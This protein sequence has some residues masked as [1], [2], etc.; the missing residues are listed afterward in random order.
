MATKKARVLVDVRIE[1]ID[2]K[3]NTVIEADEALIKELVKSG[4]LDAT[5][6]AVKY[7]VEEEG[8]KIIAH[9]SPEEAANAQKLAALMMEVEQLEVKLAAAAEAEKAELQ[10]QIDAKKAELSA[11]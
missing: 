2:Y 5:P 11:L 7:M 3:P 9:V 1:G 4:H 8:A 6:A 10:K